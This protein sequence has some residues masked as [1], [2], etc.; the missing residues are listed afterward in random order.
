MYERNVQSTHNPVLNIDYECNV[1]H[2]NV[3]YWS[4]PLGPYTATDKLLITS[5]VIFV[6][7]YFLVLVL[8]LP[9]I[10]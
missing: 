2:N 3:F 10:F 6:L 9:V 4:F 1:F 8:V 5:S 7:I